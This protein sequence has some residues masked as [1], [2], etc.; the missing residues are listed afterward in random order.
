MFN[1]K[2]SIWQISAFAAIVVAVF[3]SC[4]KENAAEPDTNSAGYKIAESEKLI[5][6]VEIELPA[7]QPGGNTR[8]VTYYA[9][10][11]QKY[12]AQLKAGSAT[13]Y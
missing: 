5:I 1:S 7:N 9:E 12:K 10:G 13:E 2:K 8:V 11:V 6:P 3:A 4:K